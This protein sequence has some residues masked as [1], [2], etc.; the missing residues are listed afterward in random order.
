M[1][2][3]PCPRCGEPWDNDS[4][5]EIAEREGEVYENV[6][7]D[8]IFSRV[9]ADFRRRGCEIF[10]VSHNT[11]GNRQVAEATSMLMDIMP[12]DFDGVVAMLQD[13][14]MV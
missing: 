4:L 6:P 1:F 11:H 9:Q 14:G 2:D 13:G 12:D 8:A 3:I 7:Y 5:H 10:D